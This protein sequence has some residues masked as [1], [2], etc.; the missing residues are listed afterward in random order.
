MFNVSSIDSSFL[1]ERYVVS[2]RLIRRFSHF[3]TAKVQHHH[4]G[5][6]MIFFFLERNDWKDPVSLKFGWGHDGHLSFG[7]NRKQTMSKPPL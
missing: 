2:P 3:D 5:S 6:R 7:Q 1:F 4:C